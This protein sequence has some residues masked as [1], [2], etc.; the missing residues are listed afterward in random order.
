VVVAEAEAGEDGAGDP[1]LLQ[2]LDAP[3]VLQDLRDP[4]PEPPVVACVVWQS[5]SSSARSRAPLIFQDDHTPARV[6][7]YFTMASTEP[8][9]TGW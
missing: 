8:L 3:V 6:T 2:L 1:D 9:V 4:L 7:A 5:A